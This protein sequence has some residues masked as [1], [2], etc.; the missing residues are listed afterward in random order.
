M[1]MN[2][3]QFISA[4]PFWR[5]TC[6]LGGVLLAICAA[7]PP[8]AAD[9]GD[10]VSFT[11]TVSPSKPDLGRVV[12]AAS[13]TTVYQIEPSVGSVTRLSGGAVRMTPDTTRATV[14]IT[15]Q[16]N[17]SKDCEDARI[18]VRIGSIGTPTG[19]AGSL[20]NFTV[21]MG[22]AELHPVGAPTGA[23]PL[24][25][26]LKP[27]PRNQSR[28]FYVG[29]D[30]PVKGDDSGANTGVS[31][32]GFYVYVGK[33]PHNP[34]TGGTGTGVVTVYRPISLSKTGDLKF[35]TIV[36]PASGS[37][38]VHID[39]GN[40]VR[41]VSGGGA[42]VNAPAP[43]PA[44]YIIGGEGGQA[45]SVSIPSSFTLAGPTSLTVT[46]NNSVPVSPILSS[47]LGSAGSLSFNVGG[48]FTIQ[49]NTPTGS[50][51]GS[52]PVTVNYN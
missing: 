21:E 50:Y 16:A 1:T 19:R 39:S 11:V 13:G 12:S 22:T 29:M 48:Q 37:S 52:F 20:N 25:M 28:T 26:S 6:A 49:S 34:T 47:G 10:D 32:S 35:G 17:K 4:V 38:V 42:A 44:A 18:Q 36:R 41:T 43:A 5:S 23:N 8:A 9:E 15:C 14:T 3:S 40:G 51:T 31:T 27:I 46:T 2:L 45:V 30:F 7:A 24:A 33:H